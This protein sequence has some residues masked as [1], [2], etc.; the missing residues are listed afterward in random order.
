VDPAED[1]F[2]LDPGGLQLFLAVNLAH[3]FLSGE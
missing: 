1:R 2:A 3:G